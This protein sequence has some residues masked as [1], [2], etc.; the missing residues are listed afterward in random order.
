MLIAIKLQK[1]VKFKDKEACYK[2]VIEWAVELVKKWVDQK[3]IASVI[4]I[5][6]QV[7]NKDYV[8][9]EDWLYLQW[10]IG[11]NV[12]KTQIYKRYVNSYAFW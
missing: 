9:A 1:K 6:G 4:T 5:D 8:N 3:A 12:K 2:E 7:K 11:T 10:I